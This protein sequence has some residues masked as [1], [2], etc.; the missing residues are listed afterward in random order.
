[1]NQLH[2][3]IDGMNKD[4]FNPVGLNIVW[5]K[6]AA[7]IFV[8]DGLTRCQRYGA[9][10]SHPCSWRLNTMYAAS[11]CLLSILGPT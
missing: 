5:P 3:L 2:Q 6:N 4:T 10:T 1:M 9:L 11:F 8:S 7:F